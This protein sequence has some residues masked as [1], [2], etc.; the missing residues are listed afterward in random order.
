MITYY[1]TRLLFVAAFFSGVA[2]GTESR[3]ADK[4]RDWKGVR[5]QQDGSSRNSYGVIR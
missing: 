4:P 1:T 2:Q 3:G 5:W